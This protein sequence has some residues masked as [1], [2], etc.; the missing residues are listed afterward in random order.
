MTEVVDS[1]I[2][3]VREDTETFI[4]ETLR[5]F[6]EEKVQM[7]VSKHDLEQALLKYY[8]K[9][10][11]CSDCISRQAAIDKATYIETE[12]GWSGR[13][14]DVKDIESL[15]SVTPKPKIGHWI[16]HPNDYE[17]SECH[18]IR[19]KG[20]TGKYNYCPNCGADMRGDEN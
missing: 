18:I 5:P 4:F 14:V 6:C 9:E 11:T 7:K 20:R 1:I 16:E 15:P 10:N 12:E 2:M 19:A 13:M 3:Q 17:C 8:G